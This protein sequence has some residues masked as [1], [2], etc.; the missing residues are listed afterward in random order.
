MNSTKNSIKRTK[1]YW[2]A[3]FM[4]INHVV[5]I[6]S[7]WFAEIKKRDDNRRAPANEIAVCALAPPT[8]REPGS[9]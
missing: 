1:D 5:C 7:N 4:N 8:T 3:I 6:R 9:S 2:A